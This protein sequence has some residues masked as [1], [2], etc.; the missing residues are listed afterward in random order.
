MTNP[1]WSHVLAL[2]CLG[3]EESSYY[4]LSGILSPDYKYL[5]TRQIPH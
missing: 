5:H 3:I 2:E 4:Q 1:V